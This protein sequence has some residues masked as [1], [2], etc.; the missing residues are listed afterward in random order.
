MTSLLIKDHNS[1]LIYE[2]GKSRD[3]IAYVNDLVEIVDEIDPGCK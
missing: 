2:Y 3:D 1:R